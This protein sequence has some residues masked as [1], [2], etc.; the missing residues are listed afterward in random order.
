[1]EQRWAAAPAVTGT[2]VDSPASRPSEASTVTSLY[3]IFIV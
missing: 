3:L 1:M 2:A